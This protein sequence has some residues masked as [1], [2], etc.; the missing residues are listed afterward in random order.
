MTNWPWWKHN[1]SHPSERDLLLTV[2]GEGGAR[3]ARRVRDH[4]EG[5]WSCALKRDRL[6]GAIAAFMRERETGLGTEELSETADRRFESRL[7]RLAQQVD[8]R[9]PSRQRRRLLTFHPQAAVALSL[10]AVFAALIWLRFS[11]VPSVSAREVLNRAE[12][13]EA[14]RI[15]AVNEPVIHQQFQVTRSANGLSLESTYLE[16]WHDPKSN[17]WRQETEEAAAV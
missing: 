16:I 1:D 6:A 10:M 14:R 3:L 2:N 9:S 5:C 8:S 11:S 13:A 7:R 12:R 17:R 15:E 4:V